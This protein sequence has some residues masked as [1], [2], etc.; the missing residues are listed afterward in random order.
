MMGRWRGMPC[1]GVIGVQKIAVG[2][3]G[4]RAGARGEDANEESRQGTREG[5]RRL[6]KRSI[7]RPVW[8]AGAVLARQAAAGA[9][10]ARVPK[11]RSG[12]QGAVC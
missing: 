7:R 6:T 1:A 3:C 9:A 10:L 12:R 11:R 4:N 8:G 5:Q 2:G